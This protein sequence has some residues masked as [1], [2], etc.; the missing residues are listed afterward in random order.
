[1]IYNIFL[2]A[3][4]SQRYSDTLGNLPHKGNSKQQMQA[5]PSKEL[6]LSQAILNKPYFIYSD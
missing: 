5:S 3:I 4:L 1:M 6:K 2:A